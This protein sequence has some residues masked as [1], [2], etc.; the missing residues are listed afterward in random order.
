MMADGALSQVGLDRMNGVMAGHVER[1]NVPGMVTVVS[2]RDEVRVDV[3][4]TMAFGGGAP[5]QRDTIFR[6]ASV[7][8]P[9]VAAAAMILV[10]ECRLRLDE[11]VD[12]LL[13][14]L[15]NRTVLKRLD[16]PISETVPAERPISLR[17]LLTMRMGFG[18]IIGA[19]DEWPIQ[20][21]MGE[22]G[23]A[24]GPVMTT[25]SPGAW[26]ASLGSL[27]LMHQPGAA[28]MYDQAF[29]VLGIL[30]E[31][32]AGQPLERFLR[33]RIFGP[34]GMKDTGFS[35]PAEAI[36]R[37]PPCYQQAGDDGRFGLFDSGAEA[38]RWSQSP[39]FSSGRG[40][41][42]STADDVLAFGRMMLGKG[43]LG[44]ERILS[45]PSVELMTTD[46]LTAEQRAGAGFFLG[47]ERGWGFG[48]SV[49]RK[50]NDVAGS[51]GRYGWDGGYGTS[52]HA[53]P[54]EDLTAVMLSQ[55]LT[56]PGDL[57]EDFWTS[58]YQSIGD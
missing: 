41:L 56:F 17:D 16:G 15:A 30:V 4:G 21:A 36:H 19:A 45:R 46:Q 38:S 2:R 26:L 7:T 43:R 13:P 51:P 53:D 47:G 25:V 52:W 27:P 48:V 1:G 35:V 37:L 20:Q 42:V 18:Y 29:D 6:I 23:V 58:V 33:E 57:Y 44:S 5:M 55:V 39:A 8:K 50:R 31:R 54:G 12:R 11:P 3:L 14:E 24:G 9:M 40:G 34:L 28:W 49:F 32:A 10:E 22:R